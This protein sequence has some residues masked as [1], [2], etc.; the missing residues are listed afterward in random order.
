MFFTYLHCIPELSNYFILNFNSFT[1]LIPIT[2]TNNPIITKQHPNNFLFISAAK[3]KNPGDNREQPTV[4]SKNRI[5]LQF[6]RF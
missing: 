1:Y 2:I 5:L 6:E 3:A 4:V